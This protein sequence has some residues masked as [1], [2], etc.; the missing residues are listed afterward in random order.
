MDRSYEFLLNK[1]KTKQPGEQWTNTHEVKYIREYRYQQK[2][3]LLEGIINR[4]HGSFIIT[5]PQKERIKYLIKHLDFDKAN[6]KSEQIIIMI[7]IY[8]KLESQKNR[9]LSDYTHL[10]NQYHLTTNTFARFQI[11]ITQHY[12]SRVYG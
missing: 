8:V 5:K 2:I 7:I 1:Y 10:L 3:F 9:Q 4:L 6:L 12:I 11:D